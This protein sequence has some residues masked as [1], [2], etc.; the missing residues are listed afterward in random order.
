[1]SDFNAGSDIVTVSIET[2]NGDTISIPSIEW[3]DYMLSDVLSHLR[4]SAII[5]NAAQ[6]SFDEQRN[7]AIYFLNGE[8]VSNTES[9]AEDT[10]FPWMNGIAVTRIE[11]INEVKN[12]MGL[13]MDFYI[14]NASKI[15]VATDETEE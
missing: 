15:I 7:K 6:V 11:R 10:P 2:S 4:K 8:V 14:A 1:M 3:A 9:D 13:V 5:S 12:L